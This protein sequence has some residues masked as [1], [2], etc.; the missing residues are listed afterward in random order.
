MPSLTEHDVVE[1]LKE[2]RANC[3]R[4]ADTKAGPLRHGWLED[5]KYFEA[6]I[7][8]ILGITEQ[9]IYETRPESLN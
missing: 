5:A 7:M 8:F 2:R 9:D 3:L 1:W 6:A 4:I